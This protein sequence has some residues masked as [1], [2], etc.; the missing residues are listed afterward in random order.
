MTRKI[1][2]VTGSRA[3]YGLLRPV[4]AA[5]K[6]DPAFDVGLIVSAMHLS[7]EFGMTIREIEADGHR[8]D[9]KVEMLVSSDTGVGV[10]KSIGLG[11]I[12]FADAFA[13]LEPDILLLFGDRFETLAAAQAA[14][15]MRIPVAHISGGHV[16]HGAFD[17]AIR[18]CITKMAHIH[19]ATTE[20]AGSR[21]RQLGEPSESI[22]VVGDPGVDAVRLTPRLD[23]AEVE[24]RL[25]FRFR[26]RNILTT[27]HPVTLDPVPS[28]DQFE[29]VL[30]ALDSLGPE[31]G[32]ILTKPNADVEGRAL[33]ARAERF[34]EGRENVV[35]HSSLGNELYLSAL[36]FVDVVVGN[37]S[38]GL[39]EAPSLERPTV[40]IGLRQSGRPRAASVIDCPIETAA[41]LD[42]IQRAFTRDARGVV[43]PYGDGH[44]A[45]RIAAVLRNLSNPRTLL[46]KR[47]QDLPS[48]RT[49]PPT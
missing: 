1:G 32:I 48:A 22:H 23:R 24:R 12:G 45:E 33:S 10:A 47:F 40:N 19:F 34:A 14:L 5:L 42:S 8:I 2:L 25:G 6:I 41:I 3:E 30:A 43:N 20:D 38:S 27:Y 11:T 29:R 13:R 37:S 26:R 7:P 9:A 35:V 4:I 21:I 44:A 31:I 15:V 46:L 28:I 39:L 49:G 17:D 36:S 16:T 18:H